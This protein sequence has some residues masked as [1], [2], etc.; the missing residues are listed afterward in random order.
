MIIQTGKQ[1]LS[2]YGRLFQIFLTY[3]Q[4]FSDVIAR[5]FRMKDVGKLEHVS[6]KLCLYEWRKHERHLEWPE[7]Y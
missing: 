3:M 1:N 2:S 6:L 7:N 4:N 5:Q